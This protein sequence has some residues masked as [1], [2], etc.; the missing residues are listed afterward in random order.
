M[1]FH[2]GLRREINC[3]NWWRAFITS[4]LCMPVP[5]WALEIYSGNGHAYDVVSANLS[6]TNSLAAAGA[7]TPPAGFRQGH[8]VTYSDAAE[9][10]LR[11][12]QLL[13][14]HA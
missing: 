3:R 5:A 11:L 2:N 8:L 4:V 7:L 14:R 1:Q 6:W 10:K 9:E 12:V 13:S